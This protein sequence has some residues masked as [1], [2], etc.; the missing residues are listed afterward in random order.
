[1][2]SLSRECERE[3]GQAKAA[4]DTADAA[5]AQLRAAELAHV[6]QVEALQAQ[7]RQAQVGAWHAVHRSSKGARVVCLRGKREACL[8]ISILYTF[9]V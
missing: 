3:R 8:I 1:M 7:L 6:Q 9:V 4:R 2:A 5:L